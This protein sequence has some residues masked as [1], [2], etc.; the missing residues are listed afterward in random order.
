MLFQSN[1]PWSHPKEF[2]L[3]TLHLKICWSSKAL[4]TDR[5][6]F[7]LKFEIS[8]TGNFSHQSNWG[9][10]PWILSCV[11]SYRYH[12][13]VFLGSL[14]FGLRWFTA[15][16]PTKIS[17][18]SL[19]ISR[20]PTDAQGCLGSGCLGSPGNPRTFSTCS[21]WPS[22]W[23]SVARWGCYWWHSVRWPRG[24]SS[25]QPK[26]WGTSGKPHRKRGSDW[27]EARKMKL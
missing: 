16:D 11:S 1:F 3:G 25:E 4:R 2:S 22:W 14:F 26:R 23:S 19:V 7:P 15:V 24:P 13:M 27:F 21:K 5:S 8:G 9:H 10:Q 6:H 18:S 20:L 12:W 17:G